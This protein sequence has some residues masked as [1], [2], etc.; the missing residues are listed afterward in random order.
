MTSGPPA[1]TVGPVVLVGMMATGKTTVGRQVAEQ[2][3][4][5]LFDS[6]A[7]IEE[8]T[9]RTVAQLWHDGGETG[10]RSLETGALDD[11]LSAR[12]PGV[13]AAAGGVVLAPANRERL[14]RASEDGAVVIWLRAEPDVL[15]ARVRPGDHRPLLAGDPVGTLRRLAAERET[16]YAE[17]ADRVLD[18]D[19]RPA[20]DIAAAV[21]A[22][23][24]AV[25]AERS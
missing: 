18:I 14:Q 21:L 24:A 16:L 23:V 9:G 13:V 12:P 4:R 25:A 7:M 22:E 2:L 3:G 20:S 15:A 8:R 6:D 19:R 10:Y 1:G 17:V 5:R 11:A